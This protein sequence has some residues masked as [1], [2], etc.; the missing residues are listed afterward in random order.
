MA[1]VDELAAR[2]REIEDVLEALNVEYAGREMSEEARDEWN[3]LNE[4]LEA[5]QKLKDELETRAARLAALADKPQ[6]REAGTFYTSSKKSERDIYDLNQI[7]T[8]LANPE[9]GVRQLRDNARHAIERANFPHER[10][11]REDNQGHIEKML[12][13][14]DNAQG[15]LARHILMTGHPAYVR[16]FGKYI[17]G[18]PR[19]P[20]EERVMSLTSASGGYGVP[21]VLDPTIILSSDGAI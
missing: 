15:D 17:T 1:T 14:V 21:F 18:Q 5:N 6:A 11:N 9:E 8:S 16:G 13:K 12:E 4:E 19:S 10:A 7:T 2:N 3:R 20:E